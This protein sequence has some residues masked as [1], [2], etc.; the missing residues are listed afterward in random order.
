MGFT[1]IT[2]LT[3]VLGWADFAVIARIV[4]LTGSEWLR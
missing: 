1:D 4:G 2:W 3:N